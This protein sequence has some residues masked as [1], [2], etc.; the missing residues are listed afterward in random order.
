[1]MMAITLFTTFDWLFR[2]LNNSRSD[3]VNW[4]GHVRRLT[5]SFP[6]KIAELNPV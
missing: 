1:M 3:K 2:D 5:V 6:A 4:I